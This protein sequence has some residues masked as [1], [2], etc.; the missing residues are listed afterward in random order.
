MSVLLAPVVFVISREKT[1]LNQPII[2]GYRFFGLGSPIYAS[3]F[4]ERWNLSEPAD[5]DNGIIKY[6]IKYRK[7]KDRV[8]ICMLYARSFAMV[9]EGIRLGTP[10]EV[11]IP[12]EY[13]NMENLSNW[14]PTIKR[15]DFAFEAEQNIEQFLKYNA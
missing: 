15:G 2:K 5:T 8:G 3:W 13:Y 9:C 1:C 14:K 4:T 12:V 11:L 7:M 10:Q 6:L